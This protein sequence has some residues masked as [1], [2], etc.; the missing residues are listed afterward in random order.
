VPASALDV[1]NSAFQ[2]T[3]QQLFKPFR[4]GQWTRLAVIGLLAGELGT[5][6]GLGF[7]SPSFPRRNGGSANFLA[8][9]V[10]PGGP[11][12]IAMIA[13]LIVLGLALVI[14]FM[15]L[16]SRMRFVLFDSVVAKECHIRAYWSRRG[17]PAFYYFAWQ[18]LFTLAMLSGLVI[19][20]AP[21]AFLVLRLRSLGWFGS[22]GAHLVPLILGGIFFAGV[23][24][25][26]IILAILI[27]VLTKDFVVPQ[28]ALEGIG[29]VE[30]W[31]RLLSMM[32]AEKGGF[33]GYIGMKILLSIA[34]AV[35]LS[36]A[37]ITAV[38]ALLIP[39]GTLCLIA[40]LIGK[41][42]GLTWNLYTVSE[43]VMVAVVT[44]ALI[45]YI[46]ALITVPAIVFFPAYSIYFFAARYPALNAMLNPQ[47]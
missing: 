25:A 3:I 7:R 20:L 27:V 37:G 15:Y 26:F 13:M 30:G 34:A 44:V 21:V 5:S 40:V 32:S 11:M 42:I 10:F 29:A 4:L 23:F 33:A 1:V 31:R 46:V 12:L 9:A 17:G 22:P 36:I 2:H 19:I 35:V 8:Q 28:M 6:G 16:S 43:A 45:L 39:I 41:A 47:T 24:A 18:L 14:A 38:I